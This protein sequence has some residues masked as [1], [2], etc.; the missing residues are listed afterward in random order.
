MSKRTQETG[1]CCALVMGMLCLPVT[2]TQAQKPV[3]AQAADRAAGGSTNRI[4]QLRREV[5]G[6]LLYRFVSASGMAT[7]PAPLPAP[8]GDGGTAPGPVPLNVPA[9]YRP[10]ETTLE[11]IDVDRGNLARLP[12][13]AGAEL[14]LMESSFTVA[15]SV[16]V[17]VR[18][19]GKPVVGALVVLESKDGKFRQTRLLSPTD[20]GVAR[21]ENVPLGAPLTA[22]VRFGAYPEKSIGQTLT[23]D[24]HVWQTIEVDWKEVRTGADA[25]ATL[26]PPATLPP[27]GA[28][29]SERGSGSAEPAAGGGIGSTLISLAFLAAC[30]YGIYRAYQS[31]KLKTVLEKLGIQVAAP[32]PA[33]QPA[34]GPFAQVERV[35]V[36]P[37][38]EGTADPFA[39]AAPSGSVLPV[40]GTGNAGP[41]LI[42]TAGIYSGQIFPLTGSS[43]DIGR[44]PSNAIAL[45]QDANASRR[46]ATIQVVDGQY[47]LVDV[48]SSNGTF[49]NGVRIVQQ[50]PQPLRPGDE[51]TVGNTRFRFEA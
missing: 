18:S 36:P 39:S 13:R 6:D 42:G 21:F 46:H 48:G 4:V 32:V 5:S 41:R 38:T 26:D 33:T 50:T 16:H 20:N 7:P 19:A 49:V 37:I 1:V 12:V 47:L 2:W 22:T 35:P 45:T 9:G 29:A 3:P 25:N 51:L 31:G 10:A 40:S 23:R 14:R 44:D 11:V 27:V 28:S 8:A 17:P 43:V 30:S 34:P 15:Q 24:N